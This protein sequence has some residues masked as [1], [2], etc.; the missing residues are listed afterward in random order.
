V[1]SYKDAITRDSVSPLRVP[2]ASADLGQFATGRSGNASMLFTKVL[3]HGPTKRILKKAV[4]PLL[5]K[6]E[7]QPQN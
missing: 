5:G 7:P 6:T 1:K 2:Q 4:A 3:F